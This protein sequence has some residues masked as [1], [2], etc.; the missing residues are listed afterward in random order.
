M[1]G[2][3]DSSVAAKILKDQGHTVAGIFLHFWKSQK[4]CGDSKFCQTVENK[5]CSPQ[6]L[7]DARRVC[8]KI[9]IPL[10]TLD[11]KKE[12]KKE[13]VDVFLSEYI[14]GKTPNPCVRC[15]RFVKLG[16][17]I[18]K[19]RE[20]GFDAV[21]SGHYARTA[22]KRAN[23]KQYVALLKARDTRKDQSYFL[24]YLSQDQ[25]SQ[26]IFPLG[27]Y[28]KQQVREM[29]KKY[30]LPTASKRDSQEVCFF[31]SSGLGNFLSEYMSLKP[32]DVKTSDSEII[33]QHKGLPL[34]TIGQRKGIELGGKGPFYVY[35]TDY[36]TNT[37]FVTNQA[38]D[39]VLLRREFFVQNVNWINP[40][41]SFPLSCAVSIRY[42]G[43]NV[44]CIV[45]KHDAK[46][47]FLVKLQ[48]SVR[49]ITPGQSAV[50]YNN[51]EI[52]GGG[53]I[54]N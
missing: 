38:S 25:I 43:E 50:F 3:V 2:G 17:L 52:L 37:L 20:L 51:E 36:A 47:R 1:S 9:G 24:H 23:N 28:T 32:G 8:E 34:Y 10:Y 31:P 7:A 15:N 4:K 21:A 16:L 44:G 14:T 42:G 53:V 40:F 30:V 13:V 49:A 18:Q 45:E 27:E 12:F 6:A 41:V 11:F 29:A 5:C 46:N 19:A 33:G 35:K 54:I 26:L 22:L 48:K 39:G